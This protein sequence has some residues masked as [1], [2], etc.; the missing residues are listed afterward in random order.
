MHWN[1]KG[2]DK[3]NT[4]TYCFCPWLFLRL[5]SMLHCRITRVTETVFK[6]AD[7]VWY[8]A[9][10]NSELFSKGNTVSNIFLSNPAHGNSKTFSDFTIRK[11]TQLH[12]RKTCVIRTKK[13]CRKD[14][15]FGGRHCFVSQWLWYSQIWAL[16]NAGKYTQIHFCEL[17]L[18]HKRQLIIQTFQQNE[19]T[20]IMCLTAEWCMPVMNVTVF[21]LSKQ[22]ALGEKG[23][24]QIWMNSNCCFSIAKCQRKDAQNGMNSQLSFCQCK[25][26]KKWQIIHC[27]FCLSCLSFSFSVSFSLTQ[28]IYGCGKRLKEIF[29]FFCFEDRVP[30]LSSEHFRDFSTPTFSQILHSAEGK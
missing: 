19:Q 28:K 20:I 25:V 23:K 18:L 13:P 14:F 24:H 11:Y 9:M 29:V 27:L 7:V 21:I 2:I 12:L 17:N 26:S 3:R 6:C 4:D 8:K 5:W 1:T 30:L 10:S 22:A 15:E 16:W